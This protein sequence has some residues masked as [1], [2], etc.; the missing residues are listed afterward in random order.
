M[1]E[2]HKPRRF[3]NLAFVIVWLLL[4]WINAMGAALSEDPYS[5]VASTCL[6]CII[7]MLM[8]RADFTLYYAA[9][10]NIERGD[11]KDPT[12]NRYSI[13]GSIGAGIFQ[14]LF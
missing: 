7:D 9:A 13:L 8:S 14:P 3:L 12:M 4:A 6:L 1:P 2:G 5:I 10:K 11:I